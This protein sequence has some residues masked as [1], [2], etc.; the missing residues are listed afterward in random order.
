MSGHDGEIGQE[1]TLASYSTAKMNDVFQHLITEEPAFI[2]V[3][4]G[5]VSA[6]EPEAFRA[7]LMVTEHSLGRHADGKCPE[8]CPRF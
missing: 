1:W 8:Q 5:Y 3:L 2:W 4:M 6:S 7:G